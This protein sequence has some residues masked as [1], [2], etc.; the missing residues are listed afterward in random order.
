[1]PV[2]GCGRL[3][4]LLDLEML[5]RAGTTVYPET[6]PDRLMSMRTGM[7][8]ARELGGRL[9]LSYIRK[10]DV[11]RRVPGADPNLGTRSWPIFTTPTPYSAVEVVSALALPWPKSLRSHVILLDAAKISEIQGPRRVLCGYGLE[12][13]LPNG[14][15]S[16]ALRVPWEIEVR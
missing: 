2:T 10:D 9:L 12:Y 11:S 1:M 7:D 5:L 6:T 16:D 8:V 15:P 14:F 3:A 4:N 13:L